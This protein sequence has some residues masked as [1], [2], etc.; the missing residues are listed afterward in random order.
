MGEGAR[1]S[2]GQRWTSDATFIPVI[3]ARCPTWVAS[4]HSITVGTVRSATPTP[5]AVDTSVAIAGSYVVVASGDEASNC[6]ALGCPASVL[7]RHPARD[8]FE[9]AVSAV[10]NLLETNWPLKGSHEHL[11]DLV[12]IAG[13]ACRPRTRGLR[14]PGGRQRRDGPLSRP[15]S[16]RHGGVAL[17]SLSPRLRAVLVLRCFLDLDE[18]ATADAHAHAHRHR[19]KLHPSTPDPAAPDHSVPGPHPRRPVERPRGHLMRTGP[20]PTAVRTNSSG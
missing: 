6:S 5:V 4:G 20:G 2:N 10:T 3:G 18:P 9:G 13:A 11:Q 8:D 1:S 7:D 17:R 16:L 14:P 15:A 19:Q 12:Q